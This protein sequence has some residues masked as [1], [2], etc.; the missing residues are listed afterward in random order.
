MN[1]TG[2]PQSYKKKL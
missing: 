1:M 2:V